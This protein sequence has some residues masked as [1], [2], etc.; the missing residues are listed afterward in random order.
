MIFVYAAGGAIAGALLYAAAVKCSDASPHGVFSLFGYACWAVMTAV[1]VPLLRVRFGGA[2][3]FALAAAALGAMEFHALTDYR[4]GYICD[5][6]VIVS[7]LTGLVLRAIA[8]G[9]GG[10]FDAL[11]GAAAGGL[12]VTAVIVLTR[13]AMGWG[14][15]TMMTGLGAVLGWRMTLLTLYA[16]VIIGGACAL[17]LLLARRVK[18]R[19]ALPLAPFLLAGLMWALFFGPSFA[20]RLGLN[21]SL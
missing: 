15:A 14:D 12:P 7:F 17:V 19:D 3:H 11:L 5:G 1:F 10:V 2:E 9:I 20:A 16:G 21:V 6:A 18:R 4:G 8:G 13:G